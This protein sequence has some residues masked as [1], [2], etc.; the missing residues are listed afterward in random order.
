MNNIPYELIKELIFNKVRWY[1]ESYDFH[2]ALVEYESLRGNQCVKLQN[3]ST[4]HSGNIIPPMLDEIK[5]NHII[6]RIGK[7][8]EI[9]FNPY[10]EIKKCRIGNKF[11]KTFHLHDFGV[12][13]KPMLFESSDVYNLITQGFAIKET[14]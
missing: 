1:Y 3:T 12:T 14:L 8:R 10:G 13:V 11:Y 6:W 2:A 5:K 9:S 4:L 7:I